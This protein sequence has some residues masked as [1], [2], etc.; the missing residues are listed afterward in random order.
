MATLYDVPAPAKL[1]L[2]LHVTG[3]R[4]DGYHCLQTVFRF[5]DLCDTLHFERTGDGTI[6]LATVR[7]AGA[8][9]PADDDL[10]LRAARA[11]QR[12]SGTRYG[13]RIAYDKQIP[14][15]AGL[16]GGSS[17]AASTLIALNRLWGLGLTRAALLRVAG[18]LGADVPAFVFGRPSFAQGT[19]DLLQ[20][21]ALPACRYWI[22][23]PSVSVSTRAVFQDPHLTRNSESV[24]ISDFTDWLA[25]RGGL[26]GRNDLEAVVH[27][28]HP[29]VV[30]VHRAM[31]EAGLEPRLTG[32]GSCLF[33][34]FRDPAPSKMQVDRIIG[35]MNALPDGV[36]ERTWLCR[37]LSD[38]PLRGWVP[39]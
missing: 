7:G 26:F 22:V 20:A 8:A 21:V 13:A 24:K 17:D 12:L 10:V 2:F 14:I 16:G 4:P 31:L 32:S 36:V 23:R 30:R 27:R 33:A 9:A 11:L 38:H 37:G 18:P 29:L 6:A 39:D 15:G 28:H 19:G 3:Q 25:A 35:K 34:E 5:V 1:N